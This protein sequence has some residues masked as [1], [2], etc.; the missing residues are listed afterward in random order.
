MLVG[1]ANFVDAEDGKG[2]FDS[3]EFSPK[4]LTAKL[5]FQSSSWHRIQ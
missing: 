3:I 5:M 4:R 2:T 1:R